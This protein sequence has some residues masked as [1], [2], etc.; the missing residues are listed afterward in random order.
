MLAA[1]RSGQSV[2]GERREIRHA[3]RFTAPPVENERSRVSAAPITTG[4]AGV[5]ACVTV[6]TV[7]PSLVVEASVVV[8]SWVGWSVLR[9]KL[10][11]Y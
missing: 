8:T 5:R 1:P 6:A 10:T 4:L 7:S 11:V 2:G 3:R 9:S